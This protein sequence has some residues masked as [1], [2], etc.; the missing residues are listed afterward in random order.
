[1]QNAVVPIGLHYT[2]MNLLKSIVFL[3]NLKKLFKIIQPP[4][5]GGRMVCA[6]GYFPKRKFLLNNVF[7]ESHNEGC[8]LGAGCCAQGAYRSIAYALY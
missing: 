4:V 2:A 3:F 1:M 8:G 7:H 6:L 5:K